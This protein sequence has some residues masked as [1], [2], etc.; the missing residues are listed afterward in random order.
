MRHLLKVR[1]GARVAQRLAGSGAASQHLLQH[2]SRNLHQNS[3]PFV[4]R[5]LIVSS[6]VHQLY[7]QI[8]SCFYALHS[9]QLSEALLR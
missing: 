6:A 4:G 3:C 5:P 8:L 7:M 1:H 2:I 9:M